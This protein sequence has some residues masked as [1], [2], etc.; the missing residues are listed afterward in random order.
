[1][2]RMSPLSLEWMKIEIE[3]NLGV[4]F[5]AGKFMPIIT[6]QQIFDQ[7]REKSLQLWSSSLL[8][9]NYVCINICSL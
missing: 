2:S 9:L 1:M 6:I 5:K 4:F 8:M 3:R 7:I